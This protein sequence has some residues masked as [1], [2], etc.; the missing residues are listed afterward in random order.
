MLLDCK[1]LEGRAVPVPWSQCLAQGLQSWWCRELDGSLTWVN[2]SSS[3]AWL[4]LPSSGFFLPHEALLSALCGARLGPEH[5]RKNHIY[6]SLTSA[7][8]ILLGYMPMMPPNYI[9]NLT[10]SHEI[11][12]KLL[13]A[14]VPSRHFIHIMSE[15]N[16]WFLFPISLVNYF[17]C[18]LPHFNSRTY[19]CLEPP[20]RVRTWFVCFLYTSTSSY[21]QVLLM[22]LP[23]R[24]LGLSTS[25][26]AVTARRQGHHHC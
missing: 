13:T 24:I 4:T 22:L 16:S 6:I 7:K 9:C 2:A 19:I 17:Y 25:S 26:L 11:Q 5:L 12:I 1:S 3:L 10:P 8:L 21:S 23:K 14:W 15:Q 20:N 18:S